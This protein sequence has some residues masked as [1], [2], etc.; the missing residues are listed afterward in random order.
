MNLDINMNMK[1][2]ERKMF[3]IRYWTAPILFLFN[4]GTDLNTDN[5]LNPIST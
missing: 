3:D 4:I 2:F 5:V 1:E